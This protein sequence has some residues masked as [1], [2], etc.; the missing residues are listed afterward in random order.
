MNES[1]KYYARWKK[2]EAKSHILHKSI[3]MKCPGEKF[4]RQVG[5]RFVV[6]RGGGQGSNS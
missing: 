4:T 5:G 2:A 3:Y 6:G 1:L